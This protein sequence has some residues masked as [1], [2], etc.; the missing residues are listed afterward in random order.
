MDKFTLE[1][2]DALVG[3]GT[4]EITLEA[5]EPEF[6]KFAG[7]ELKP[8]KYGRA[9]GYAKAFLIVDIVGEVFYQNKHGV[10]SKRLTEKA[11]LTHW[12]SGMSTFLE[13]F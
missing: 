2:R 7:K 5:K 1:F 9:K 11:F 10:I 12:D 8:G 4:K 3:L 6:V 13:D